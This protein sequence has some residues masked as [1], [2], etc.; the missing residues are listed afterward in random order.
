MMEPPRL[1][2]GRFLRYARQLLRDRPEGVRRIAREY[3]EIVRVPVPG[4]PFYLLSSP[5]YAKRVLQTNSKNYRKSFDFRIVREFLGDGLITVHDEV[6]RM[7]R[8]A[9]QP[10]LK[11]D[12]VEAM[13]QAMVGVIADKRGGWEQTVGEPFFALQ[14]MTDLTLKILTLVLFDVD[15]ELDAEAISRAVN[16][17]LRHLDKRLSAVVDI[18]AWLPTPSRRRFDRAVRYL[19][20]IIAGW[21]DTR[22]GG[23]TDGD[24][25]LGTLIRASSELPPEFERRRWLR[26]QVITFLMAGHETSAVAMSW[27]LYLLTQHPEV[28]AKLA[29]ECRAALGERLPTRADLPQLSY[30]QMVIREVLRLYPPAWSLGREAI[31]ADRFD[32]YTIPAGATVMVCP[33]IIQRHPDHWPNPDRFE[34]ERFTDD[35]ELGKTAFSWL[36]FSSGPRYCM[37]AR[38]GMLELQLILAMITQ[39][40]EV[41][42]V[43]PFRIGSDALISLRPH[44]DIPL[45]FRVR[46]A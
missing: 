45:R 43:E 1:P 32:A 7:G 11:R 14:R 35:L 33:Y 10:A 19:D 18:H 17:S 2:F 39:R 31:E 46:G 40:F 4:K 26:D 38:L 23:D 5:E 44:P 20:E 36:P 42:L 8:A 16:T 37:G 9:A 25:L 41:S 13:T 30:H 6:W 27:C 24:D 29:D 15:V 12:I 34:P 3:G 28:Q 21:I 22:M